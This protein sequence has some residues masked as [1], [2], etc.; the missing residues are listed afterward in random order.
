MRRAFLAVAL[1]GVL[2][3][4]AACDSDRA[5]EPTTAAPATEEV[6]PSAEPTTPAPDYSADTRKVC[7]QVDVIFHK[8]IAAFSTEMGKMIARKETKSAPEAKAA[9]TA[10][11]GKLKTISASLRKTT[12]VAQDPDL[13]AAGA[14]SAAKFT[15]ASANSAYFTR[16]KTQ[17]DFD[18]TIQ[19]QLDN[20]MA[21]VSGFCAQ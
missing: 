1:G 5:A 18:K 7:G 8:N 20:W 12:A 9:Q 17:K 16:I 3:T 4:A 15:K 10:A 6:T 14:A 2:L 19:T 11:S 13:K 21:P